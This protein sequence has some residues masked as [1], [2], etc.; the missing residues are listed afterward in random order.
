MSFG[1]GSAQM[2]EWPVNSED[3]HQ[4]DHGLHEPER[5]GDPCLAAAVEIFSRTVGCWLPGHVVKPVRP[6]RITVEFELDGIPARKHVQPD[7]ENLN[8]LVSSLCRSDVEHDLGCNFS[9]MEA[10]STLQEDVSISLNG[11]IVSVVL[12]SKSQADTLQLAKVRNNSFATVEPLH[13]DCEVAYHG[14]FDEDVLL[15]VYVLD[16]CHPQ[17]AY[18]QYTLRG[19]IHAMQMPRAAV[20]AQ[21]GYFLGLVMHKNLN[22]D[23]LWKLKEEDPEKYQNFISRSIPGGYQ[24]RGSRGDPLAKRVANDADYLIS[25]ST[26]NKTEN[27]ELLRR[28]SIAS[29]EGPHGNKPITFCTD[30]SLGFG[31]HF[32]TVS[33]LYLSKHG[34][35]QPIA[36][37]AWFEEYRQAAKQ[38]R[39]GILVLNPSREYFGSLACRMEAY[40]I[41]KERRFYYVR[42]IDCIMA[43]ASLQDDFALAA[44]VFGL[45]ELSRVA[46]GGKLGRLRELL[47]NGTQ[48]DAQ[49]HEGAT[50]L[51]HAVENGHVD[52]VRMLLEMEADVNVPT[53][54]GI[55]ALSVAMSRGDEEV[56]QMLLERRAA[57]NTSCSTGCSVLMAAA[58]HGHGGVAR[59]LLE[60]GAHA[61]ARNSSGCTALMVAAQEGRRELVQVL[62]EAG[63]EVDALAVDGS[64]ALMLAARAGRGAV[65]WALLKGRAEV[66]VQ[67][68]DGATA[69][70]LGANEGYDEIVRTLL[71]ARANVD[72]QDLEDGTTVLMRAAHEGHF[73]VTRA[74]LHGKAEVDTRCPDGNTALMLAAGNGC[75]ETVRKLLA[76]RA[77]TDAQRPDGFTAL[78][79][80]IG[81]GHEGVVRALIEGGANPGGEAEICGK[82][83]QM[84]DV[85][86]VLGHVGIADALNQHLA[87]HGQRDGLP[88]P[89]QRA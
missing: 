19:Y 39:H 71:K 36:Q 82:R 62:L 6:G 65:L 14:S 86:R 89:R 80:A 64:T 66:D 49:D 15:K 60:C 18:D 27:D 10:F 52:A 87:R 51:M 83:Y 61:N 26:G 48:V 21:A 16:E 76:W 30:R 28:L 55:T 57:A 54:R 20:Q 37:G 56:V 32:D 4:C 42:Q 34:F 31:G 81:R 11:Q 44:A 53:P 41:P 68:R 72:A 25:T 38:T 50:A 75:V 12:E 67:R 22:K 29:I 43:L 70:H 78:L 1:G 23:W 45:G 73:E 3:S 79:L 84:V 88:S 9:E 17:D 85:A 33:W 46:G 74:L 13:V 47:A 59:M 63:A 69:L 35:G 7:S 40:Q 2:G 58:G 8:M 24:K 77:K 5:A